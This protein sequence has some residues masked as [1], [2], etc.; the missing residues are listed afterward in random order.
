M[1]SRKTKDVLRKLAII[2][3]SRTVVH[4]VKF[5]MFGMELT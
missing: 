3:F 4:G 2:M 1:I 5:N